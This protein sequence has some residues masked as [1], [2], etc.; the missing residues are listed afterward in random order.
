MEIPAYSVIVEGLSCE[1]DNIITYI[2]VTCDDKISV[3]EAHRVM[4]QNG[5]YVT[6]AFV[7]EVWG[8]IVVTST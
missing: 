3:R 4:H 7:L 6:V 5:L 2:I 1:V 8:F